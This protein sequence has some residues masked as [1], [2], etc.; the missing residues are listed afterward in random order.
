MTI[1]S[2]YNLLLPEHLELS[3]LGISLGQ[4]VTT[5]LFGGCV[6]RIAKCNLMQKERSEGGGS[7]E[8]GW[9]EAI[10]NVSRFY[11]ILIYRLYPIK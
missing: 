4:T 6:P 11:L 7:C 8:G 9:L 2:L 3:F 1:F 5:P 10:K